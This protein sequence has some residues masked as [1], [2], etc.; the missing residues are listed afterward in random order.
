MTSRKISSA[1]TC[2]LSL[3]VKERILLMPWYT[4]S[5]KQGLCEKLSQ[6]ILEYSSELHGI[7]VTF[8]NLAI[9]QKT[10]EIHDDNPHIHFDVKYTATIFQ[11]NLGAVIKAQINKL[12]DE[13]LTCLVYGCFTVHVNLSNCKHDPLMLADLEED[14]T[15]LICI[16]KVPDERDDTLHGELYI[17][18]PHRTKHG[19][20][21][22]R[23]REKD[24]HSKKEEPKL[25]KMKPLK[26]T[27]KDILAK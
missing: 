6:G 22:S 2:F 26:E 23:K 18:K 25:K 11:P 16:T 9:L 13:Y 19:L 7:L 8:S 24:H 20:K 14:K 1:G 27:H 5:I 4:G 15:V 3:E 10:G 12:G 21:R 17:E